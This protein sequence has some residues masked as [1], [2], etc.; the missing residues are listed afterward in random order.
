M[1]GEWQESNHDGD[2]FRIKKRFAYDAYNDP[3]SGVEECEIDELGL[4]RNF[5]NNIHLP[6][7]SSMGF[8]LM[9]EITSRSVS[10]REFGFSE[11]GILSNKPLMICSFCSR[12]S[13][14]LSMVCNGFDRPVDRM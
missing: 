2:D 4:E 9:D 14:R 5:R 7:R 13:N 12:V 8:C 11:C 10:F 3:K 6:T 1:G